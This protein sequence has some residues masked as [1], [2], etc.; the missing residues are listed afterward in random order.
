MST[1][2]PHHLVEHVSFAEQLVNAATRAI[3]YMKI[4][5]AMCEWVSAYGV[6]LVFSRNEPYGSGPVNG[7]I[8]YGDSKTPSTIISMNEK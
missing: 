6:H 4:A 3:C 5:N 2:Q 8:C 7:L 1:Q